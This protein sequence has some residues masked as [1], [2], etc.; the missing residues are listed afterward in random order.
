MKKMNDAI[1]FESCVEIGVTIRALEEWLAANP[2]SSDRSTI[3][4]LVAL[5]DAMEMS[6]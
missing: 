5:L 3:K 1:V 6:W 4:E 2:R